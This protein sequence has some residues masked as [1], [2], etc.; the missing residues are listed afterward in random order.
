MKE[1]VKPHELP[2]LLDPWIGRVSVLS[3]DCFDTLVWRTTGSPADVF[4]RVGDDVAMKP[5]IFAEALA[6]EMRSA[7]TGLTEVNLDEIYRGLGAQHDEARV[8]G[9]VAA[10]IAAERAH[11]FAFAPTVTLIRRARAAGIRVI[12]VSD[13]YLGAD[14]LRELIRAAAGPEVEAMI[15]TIYASCDYGLSKAAGLFPRIL[16]RIGTP[17][18]RILHLGDNRIADFVAAKE[19]GLN[20]VHLEQFAPVIEQ[21]LRTEAACATLFDP[22]IRRTE[23]CYQLHR[24]ALALAPALPGDPAWQL[25][26]RT[27]GPLLAGFSHWLRD[28]IA[29]AA[30]DNPQGR[31]HPLFLLRDGHL[32]EQVFSALF[33]DLAPDVRRIE[34]SRFV[35]FA[36]SMDS[37]ASVLRYLAEF[38]ATGRFDA[39]AKQLLFDEVE[40]VALRRIAQESS[41]PLQSFTAEVLKPRNLK[42]ILERSAE[43][44]LRLLT[45]L[46]NRIDLAPGD[47]VLLVDLGYAGTVQD[48]VAPLLR[49]RLGVR[50]QGCYLA[51]RDVPAWR[52]DKCG[53]FDPDHLDYRAIDGL[54]AYIAL[55]EQLCTIEQ[56]SIVD[57]DDAGN[58]IRRSTDLKQRQSEVRA[59]VQAGCLGFVALQGEAIQAAPASADVAA[60]R[61]T[62]LGCLARLLFY[63]QAAELALFEG[64]EHDVNMGVDDKVV[65]FDPDDAREAMI[66]RGL[67][68]VNDNPR[69]FL[70]A[71]I[72]GLGTMASLSLIALQRFGLELTH[73]DFYDQPLR[74]PIMLADGN[75]VIT[76]EADAHPTH[77]GYYALTVAA[78]AGSYSIGINL[79]QCFEWVQIHSATSSAAGRYLKKGDLDQATDRLPDAAYEQIER[80]AGELLHCASPDAFVFFPPLPAAR[81]QL[82]TLTFRP[83]AWRDGGREAAR[84]EAPDAAADDDAVDPD[85]AHRATDPADAL[86]RGATAATP[87]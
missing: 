70:P 5:R 4:L 8:A 66:R 11:C 37:R 58:P 33:P 65:L 54:C 28:R 60:W 53:F 26:Y 81:R 48:R 34:L 12:V 16:P 55:V 79:G 25:G 18:R 2:D 1:S 6:R 46:R 30:K 17:A 68:Y 87:G 31:V 84:G 86:P 73:A 62:A 82:L 47:T 44:A 29:A 9:R 39:L 51:L 63:P 21:Q 80:H 45:Y 57:Y 56:A 71:E 61:T 13:T 20:A 77:D 67:F 27:V 40:A 74:L 78:G 41:R 32:P 23:P 69:Q 75:E 7:D 14:A 38:G 24:A 3:L 19:A 83:I 50:V 35:A 43:Y 49:A 85:G 76:R 36:C 15:D 72:R 59:R 10:E 42:K 52:E 22:S 64:F